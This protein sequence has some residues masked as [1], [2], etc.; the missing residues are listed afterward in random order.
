MILD[1]ESLSAQACY[2]ILIGTVVPR[3]I[4]WAS[5][6]SRD[7]V[8]NVAPF[9]FFT[10]VCRKPPMVS[11]TIQPRSNGVTLKDTLTNIRDTGEFV[12]NIVSLPQANAMHLSSVEYQPEADE[13]DV[14]GLGKVRSEVVSAP[15]VL[16][17]P[18]AME[19]RLERVLPLGDAGDHLVIGRIVRFHIRDDL[20]LEGGRVDTAALLP[21]GRLA[22]EYT[23]VNTVFACP[24]NASTLDAHAGGRMQR[25]DSRAS[26]WS[27]LDQKGWSAA[28]NATL[29]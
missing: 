14:T 17:A 18:A 11:L 12:V 9:S 4:G 13:F 23:L 10:V 3:A 2:K 1:P 6:V 28:G 7:G 19:C 5:T 27:P 22:A 8:A 25:L 29:E 16:D 15:R 21:V 24:V 26:S 20:W